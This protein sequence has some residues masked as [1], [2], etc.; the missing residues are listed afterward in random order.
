VAAFAVDSTWHSS[1]RVW[2]LAIQEKEKRKN[3]LT[4]EN[5]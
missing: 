5:R 1:M 4:P 3:L 2:L